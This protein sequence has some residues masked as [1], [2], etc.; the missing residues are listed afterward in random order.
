MPNVGH[1]AT[2]RQRERISA[3]GPLIK[4]EPFLFLEIVNSSIE[5]VP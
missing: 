1:W 2:T 5:A 4:I 3:I